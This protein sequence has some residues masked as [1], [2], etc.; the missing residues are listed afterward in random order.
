LDHAPVSGTAKRPQKR[1]AKPRRSGATALSFLGS[2]KFAV[3]RLA[4]VLLLVAKADVIGKSFSRNERENT[5]VGYK[6]PSNFSKQ[7]IE[8]WTSVSKWTLE[9]PQLQ[10]SHREE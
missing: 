1:R 10:A 4:Q 7:E 2:I 6:I 5:V 8:F 3:L 9:I